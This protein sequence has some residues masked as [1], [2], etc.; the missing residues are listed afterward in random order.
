MTDGAGLAHA[1]IGRLI[2][3]VVAEHSRGDY[4]G[5][6]VRAKTE[7]FERC[8]PVFEDDELYDSRMAAFLEWYAVERPLSTLVPG[9]GRTPAEHLGEG[10]LAAS[11]RSL[12]E[13]R[14][15]PVGAVVIEDL[16]GGGL[17][18]VDERR[19]IAGIAEGDIFEA[20]LYGL[21]GQVV[22]GRCFLPHERGAAESIREL[23]RRAAAA[24]RMGDAGARVRLCERLAALYLKSTR[25][26]NVP[27][28]RLYAAEAEAK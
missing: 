14:E 1:E 5:E 3:A 13:V 17:F 9:G 28:A 21:G 15:L 26:K 7:F 25:Y 19:R 4:A 16:V 18:S 6:V 24:I 8:G 22:F 23:A 2:D 12:F 11:H 10:A 27:A 20:R